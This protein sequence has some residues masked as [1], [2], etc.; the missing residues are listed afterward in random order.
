MPA[1]LQGE[2][3]TL[4]TNDSIH[5]SYRIF[6]KANSR[7]A[8]VISPGRTEPAAKYAEV[9]SDLSAAGYTIFILDHRGQGESD[10]LLADSQIGHVNKFQDY[11]D[12]F[13][14]FMDVVVNPRVKSAGIQNLHLLA[15][16]MGAAI[17]TIYLEQNESPF[18]S[19]ALSSP[20]FEPD[21]APYSRLEAEAI[22]QLNLL[23]GHGKEYVM[24]RGAYDPNIPVEKSE[25]T[26]SVDRWSVYQ[27]LISD[28]PKLAIGGPSYHWLSEV[29]KIKARIFHDAIDYH[30][31][32]LLLEAS[33]DTV[34]VEKTEEAFC[35][36]VNAH[37]E[38]NCE[39]H[40]YEGAEHEILMEKDEYRSDAMAKISAWFIAHSN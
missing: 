3:G 38:I 19:A 35:S 24:G 32:S 10:R 26:H 30:T 21:L 6:S 40:F 27:Q 31:P 14:L 22:L 33:N 39:S 34:V 9:I 13:K 15:H 5:L 17:T 7:N 23:L 11:V 29:L 36:A 12:D 18:R 4:T 37:N 1:Y 20:M 28:F 25:L 16:S 8:I 2:A